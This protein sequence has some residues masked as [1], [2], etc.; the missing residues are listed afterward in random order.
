LEKKDLLKKKPLVQVVLMNVVLNL[1]MR[2]HSEPGFPA[3]YKKPRLGR[4]V[5]LKGF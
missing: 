3:D 2:P 4:L 5:G 1:L